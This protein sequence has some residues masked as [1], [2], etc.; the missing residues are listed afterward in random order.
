M[1]HSEDLWARGPLTDEQNT[2]VRKIVAQAGRTRDLVSN[3]LSFAQQSPGEKDL[4][5]LGSLL[6]RATQMLDAKHAGG[7][8]RIEIFIEPGFPRVRG[9][10]NQLFQ[11]LIEI[12]ENAID[13]L[14]E[15]GGGRLEI[16][17]QRLGHEVVL[18][19]S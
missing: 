19:F 12:V 11:A 13:A 7:N 15:S 4:L 16:R 18:Q 2:L 6:S 8:I 1:H 5:D 3:L 9:N 17:A 10:V 14:Q